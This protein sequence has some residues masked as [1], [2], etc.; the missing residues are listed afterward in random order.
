MTDYP[1]LFRSISSLYSQTREPSFETPL[2]NFPLPK[3]YPEQQKIILAAKKEL[4][5]GSGSVALTSHTGFGKTAM[6]LAL[7]R[8]HP[9][10][11]IEPR[12][13]L[14]KQCSEGY[15][16]DF[17]L[18]G[19]SEYPCMHAP[20]ASIA[21][22]QRRISC[23]TTTWHDQCKEASQ[24]CLNRSCALFKSSEKQNGTITYM[25]YPCPGCQYIKAQQDA[26]AVLKNGGT[27]ICNFANFWN[28]MKHVDMVV[29][30]E[31]DLFFREIAKPTRLEFSK[32]KEYPNDSIAQLL[33]RELAGL[34]KALDT[35]PASQIYS[36]K[37][38]IYN[39]AFLDKHAEL[40]FKY[41]RKD[42]IYVEISPDK[43][44]VLKDKLFKDKKLVIVSATLGD[45]DIPK[46][47]GRIW[48]R[49][50][51]FYAPV[52]KMTA[53]ELK[54]KP[55]LMKR[56]AEQIETISGIAEGLYDTHQFVI[57]AGNI[58]THATQLNALLG[59]DRSAIKCEICGEKITDLDPDEQDVKCPKCERKWHIGEDV[60]TMHER[61]NLMRTIETFTSS[62]KRYL[63][64]ASAEYGAD[65]GWCKVQF[66]LKYPYP[67]LDDRMRTL[68]KTMG[69]VKFNQFYNGDARNRFI[70]QCGR[71]VR[72]FGDFGVT[73][74]LDS[75]AHEDFS[76]N[77]DKYPEWFRESYD[78]KPY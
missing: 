25:K 61:G 45:F 21:P 52:G 39:A 63:L 15:Y 47:E 66:I 58:G 70:Q 32:P 11:V 18:F 14:Q 35:S 54:L 51:I 71:N 36:I 2:M 6:I 38:K 22:C 69:P 20:S 34:R 49:R 1:K 78:P 48:Q 7:T 29:I 65:F 19:R 42:R 5:S 44:G 17:V 75:K 40:C 16:G 57:H 28:L 31:A 46:L 55:F 41:Q 76:R 13:F 74:V 53:R 8:G 4:E 50:G 77:K 43:T 27:V 3:I 26:I 72:G 33:A 12:K 73:I 9:S 30:D 62:T 56:A 24:T 68:E 67:S 64:V 60:C 59:P 37:N 23:E 10:V